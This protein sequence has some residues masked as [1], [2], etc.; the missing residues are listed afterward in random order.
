MF[1]AKK[2]KDDM[3]NILLGFFFHLRKQF[4]K[5]IKG[6]YENDL[7]TKLSRSD[8]EEMFTALIREE[9]GKTK[10]YRKLGGYLRELPQ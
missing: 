1:P 6:R 2:Q 7:G 4:E 3:H 9:L 10:K 5:T 8:I